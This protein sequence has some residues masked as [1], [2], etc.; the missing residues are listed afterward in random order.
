MV[1]KV[2]VF[3]NP[4]VKKDSMPLKLLPELRKAF[5]KIEFQEMDPMEG[6]EKLGRNLIILDTVK[7]IKGVQLIEDLK[8][9]E[10]RKIFSLHDMDLGFHLKLLKKMG[11]LNRVR[12]IGIPPGMKKQD[13]LRGVKRILLNLSNS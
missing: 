6:M 10:G 5:P 4:L 11:I 12:I 2:Y 13:A 7:G 9:L 8:S 3:G 1:L